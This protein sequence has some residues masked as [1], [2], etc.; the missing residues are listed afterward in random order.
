MPRIAFEAGENKGWQP[1]PKGT[2]DF[3][4]D[5]V[6][7][8]LSKQKETP[9]VMVKTHVEGGPHDQKEATIFYPLAPGAGFRLKNLLDAAGVDYEEVA[10]TNVDKDGKPLTGYN[11]DSDN[12]IDC[13]VRV[14]VTVGEWNGKPKNEFSNERSL[15]AG[16]NGAAAAAA[17]ATAP[18]AAA[19]APVAAA[20]AGAPAPAQA[21]RRR[22]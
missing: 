7:E 16:G 6:T 1:L 21:R 13:V 11:F 10:S 5:E 2:Y 4:I 19:T 15:D 20:A 22:V 17:P 14:D 3:R 18:A 9:T 12:L 8:T